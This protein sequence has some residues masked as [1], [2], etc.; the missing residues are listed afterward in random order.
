MSAMKIT[1]PFPPFG[2]RLQNK[3]RTGWRPTNG[4]NIYTSWRSARAM[5]HGVCFPPESDPAL[6]AWFFLRG[7][8]I[9]LINTNSLAS[10]S[11]LQKLAELLI[12]SGAVRVGLVDVDHPLFWYVPSMVEAAA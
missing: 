12:K 10:Y 8:D 6:Y 11:V 2:R 3:L 9:S 1:K 4:I 5:P 7:Q